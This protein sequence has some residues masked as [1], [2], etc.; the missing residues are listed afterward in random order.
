MLL[1]S[2]TAYAQGPYIGG[3]WEAELMGLTD[4]D[5]IKLSGDSTL[6][7]DI[8][9]YA[10]PVDLNVTLKAEGSMANDQGLGLELDQAYVDYL[11][12]DYDLRLGKQRINW[13]T[14]VGFNPTDVINPVDISDPM[15]D[16][17]ANWAVKGEYYWGPTLELTGVYVPFFRPSLDAI[18]GKPQIAVIS[19]EDDGEW[20]VKLGAKGMAGMDFSLMYF[21]GWERMPTPR[22][23]MGG[24]QGYYRAV[25]IIGADFA[26]SIGD[27]GLW[28]EAAYSTPEGGD[29]YTNWAV[30]GDY[31][32]PNGLKIVGQYFRQATTGI[33]RDYIMLGL[34]NELAVIH[35]WKVGAVYDV[36]SGDYLFNPEFNLSL[37]DGAELALGWKYVEN[38][39]SG[40]GVMNLMS[41]M[42]SELYMRLAMSF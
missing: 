28:A 25:D 31:G 5:P 10:D 17:L 40:P 1:F 34:E 8:Q 36:D 33:G 24:P 38:D 27:L 41:Q 23:T 29:A 35:R 14:A 19:P 37:A 11:A 42:E 6:Y 9:H 3:K 20:A 22:M 2:I 39:K 18:P 26:T 7:L 4:C 32:L 12:A 15:N 21:S 16:K 30:G 13:G